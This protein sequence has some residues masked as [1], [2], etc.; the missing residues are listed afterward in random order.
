MPKKRNSECVVPTTSLKF[1]R[2]RESVLGRSKRE[3]ADILGY[4]E[5]QLSK[6]AERPTH[7]KHLEKVKTESVYGKRYDVWDVHTT[8][9]RWWVVTNPTNLYPQEEMPSLDYVLSFHIGVM[10]RVA[11]RDARKAET[12]HAARFADTWRRWEQAAEALECAPDRPVSV[13]LPSLYRSHCPLRGQPRTSRRAALARP[14]NRSEA[15]SSQ[16]PRRNRPQ[17]HTGAAL[18]RVLRRSERLE[19]RID[20]RTTQVAV[21]PSLDMF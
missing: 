17:Q 5:W 11:A 6:G 12:P 2:L 18:L 9:G 10:L 14:H 13:S 15:P 1:E 4:V 7:V 20:R 19:R 16:L 3:E 21:Q 8:D